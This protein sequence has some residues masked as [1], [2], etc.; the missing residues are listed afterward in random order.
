[1]LL[2]DSHFTLFCCCQSSWAIGRK[3]LNFISFVIFTRKKEPKSFQ[4]KTPLYREGQ[5]LT[6]FNC[7]TRHRLGPQSVHSLS[8][9]NHTLF[10]ISNILQQPLACFGISSTSVFVNLEGI[11][12]RLDLLA[13]AADG[14]SDNKLVLQSILKKLLSGNDWK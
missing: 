3:F 11:L 7:A 2:A 12:V 8:Q 1:M 5:L 6:F 4:V 10:L 9:N 14:V 13:S